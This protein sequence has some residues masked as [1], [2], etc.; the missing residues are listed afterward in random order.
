MCL[1]REKENK[2]NFIMAK[3]RIWVSS[4][5][6][7]TLQSTSY[8]VEKD[9]LQKCSL[10]FLARLV[11][12]SEQHRE[13]SSRREKGRVYPATNDTIWKQTNGMDRCNRYQYFFIM[14]MS[15]FPESVM[16]TY[17]FIYVLHWKKLLYFKDSQFN[18]HL[19]FILNTSHG[20][21]HKFKCSYKVS[22]FN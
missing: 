12:S 14:N 19:L 22:E 1:K 11:C 17:C 10:I 20:T 2:N 15:I 7:K 9:F 16:K 13:L 6:T 3:W 5:N 18:H 4:W 21:T 8:I